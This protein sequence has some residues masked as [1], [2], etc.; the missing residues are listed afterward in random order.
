MPMTWL[1]RAVRWVRHPPAPGMVRLVLAV[2]AL[3]LLL[4]GV[5]RLFGW[6]EA[7]T[8]EPLRRVPAGG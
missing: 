8:V 3:A 1:L 7:L 5:E 6:P 4:Y 2:V